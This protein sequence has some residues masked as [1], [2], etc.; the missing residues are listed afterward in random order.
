M[1][2]YGNVEKQLLVVVLKERALIKSNRWKH[3]SN[4]GPLSFVL[5]IFLLA[6]QSTLE[7]LLFFFFTGFYVFMCPWRAHTGISLFDTLSQHLIFFCRH[8]ILFWNVTQYT[9][10]TLEVCVLFVSSPLCYLTWPSYKNRPENFTF[11]EL[12]GFLS[13]KLWKWTLKVQKFDFEQP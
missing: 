6:L 13:V 9:D 8:K 2:C 3:L 1:L 5:N 4:K 12:S 7:I 11:Y 10:F